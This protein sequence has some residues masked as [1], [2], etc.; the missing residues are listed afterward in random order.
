M[1]SN[2]PPSS[3]SSSMI[4]S[5]NIYYNI[6]LVRKGSM[7]K[8]KNVIYTKLIALQL[9]KYFY[10]LP[11]N[12]HNTFNPFAPQWFEIHFHVSHATGYLLDIQRILFYS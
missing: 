12:L 7:E 3:S 2:F 9:N 5:K 6:L 10:D 1:C 4:P 11:F 8:Q